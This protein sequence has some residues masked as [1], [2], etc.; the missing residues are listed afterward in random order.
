[1]VWMI[2][3]IGKGAM[4]VIWMVGF[5]MVSSYQNRRSTSETK[6]ASHKVLLDLWA[7]TIISP[8]KE[9]SKQS[10]GNRPYLGC[11]NTECHFLP[12]SPGL[13][14]FR[15]SEPLKWKEGCIPLTKTL[16][17][18][19]GLYCTSYASPSPKT[20]I[21]HSKCTLRRKGPQPLVLK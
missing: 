21:Y 20:T 16:I 10:G 7:T 1:M 3:I 19:T 6:I 17:T 13:I 11:Y 15:N 2:I 18:M 4:V 8:W 12:Q 5:W 14:Y 9:K